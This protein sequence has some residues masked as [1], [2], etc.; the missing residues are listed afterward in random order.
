MQYYT[1]HGGRS[2]SR[3]RSRTLQREPVAPAQPL[4]RFPVD[5]FAFQRPRPRLPSEQDTPGFKRVRD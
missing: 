3:A 1:A 5:K 2:K 4:N